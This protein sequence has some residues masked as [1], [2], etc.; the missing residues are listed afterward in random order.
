MWLQQKMVTPDSADPNQQTQSRMM[1]WMLPL[2]FGFFTMSFPSGLALYWVAS[3]IITIIMQYYIGGWGGL[4]TLFRPGP[5]DTDQKTQRPT[6][7]EKKKE[8]M[9]AVDADIIVPRESTE[10][11]TDYGTSGDKR[12]DSGGSY[13]DSIDAIKRQSRRSKSRRRKRR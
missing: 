12:E 11:G 2:M 4:A 1:L 10:E 5:R 8:T 3:N 9:K 7:V 6:P 13:P